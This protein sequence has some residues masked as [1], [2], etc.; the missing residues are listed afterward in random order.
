MSLNK[1]YKT[2]YDKKGTLKNAKLQTS[3]GK[4]HKATS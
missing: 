2:F 4:Y 3:F 1:V